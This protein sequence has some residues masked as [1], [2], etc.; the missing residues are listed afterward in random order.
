MVLGLLPLPRSARRQEIDRIEDRDRRDVLGAEVERPDALDDLT[1]EFA[2]GSMLPKIQAA[3][4]FARTSGKRAAIGG[5]SDI[6]G[7]LDG[8]AGTIVS[9]ESPGVTY[10]TA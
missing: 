6:T 5:L 8:T 3:S 7:M 1:G 4:E 10:R 9:V 2:A